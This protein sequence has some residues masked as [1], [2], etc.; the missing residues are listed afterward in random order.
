[1][2]SNIFPRPVYII[3]SINFSCWNSLSWPPSPVYVGS[4]EG[5]KYGWFEFNTKS[6]SFIIIWKMRVWIEWS[7]SKSLLMFVVKFSDIFNSSHLL[8]NTLS[9]LKESSRRLDKCSRRFRLLLWRWHVAWSTNNGIAPK[10]QLVHQP[11][12]WE[13]TTCTCSKKS[14]RAGMSSCLHSST[15]LVE[16][17]IYIDLYITLIL[18]YI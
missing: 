16:R 6:C 7:S 1:M 17:K 9:T 4:A 2:K 14:A 5:T 12:W 11:K 18:I 13:K 3:E 10:F 8:R 15:L